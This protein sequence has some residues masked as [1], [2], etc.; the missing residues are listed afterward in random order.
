MVDEDVPK[1][2]QLAIGWS[3]FTQR[4]PERR[5]KALESSRRVKLGDLVFHLSADKLAF[6]ICLRVSLMHR[7]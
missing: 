3:D 6:E 4:G 1:N 5:A 2:R 7:V